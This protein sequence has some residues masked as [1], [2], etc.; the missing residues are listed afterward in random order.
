MVKLVNSINQ[1]L[2]SKFLILPGLARPGRARGL[3]IKF[4]PARSQGKIRD[5][6]YQDHWIQLER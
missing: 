3:S 6:P 4:H 1:Q 5:H 2:I